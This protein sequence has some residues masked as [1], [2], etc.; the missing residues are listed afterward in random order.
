M[1]ASLLDEADYKRVHKIYRERFNDPASFT[2]YFVGNVNLKAVKPLI[3]KYLGS[4]SNTNSNEN[5]KDLNI[6]YPKGKVD[7]EVKKGS[8][9]KSTV[10]MQFNH[11]FDYNQKDRLAL[12]ALGKILS[13]DLIDEIREKNSWVYSIGAYPNYEKLPTAKAVVTVYFP[14]SPE[15]IEDASKGV[16]EIFKKVSN[17][18]PTEVNLNKAKQQ[19]L[20]ERETHMRENTYWINAMKAYEFN[21]IDYS[22]FKKEE[23]IIKSLTKEHII[24]TAK[25]YLNLDNY[26]RVYLVPEK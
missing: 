12:K 10:L 9:P 11:D 5:F 2:F 21:Q 3:E 14:T 23:A 7:V 8:E 26:I 22:E 24:A 1:S 16:L 17:D 19:L 18:G 15:H 4:L 6:N 20:K 13:I 25:K